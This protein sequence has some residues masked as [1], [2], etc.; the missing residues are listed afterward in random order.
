MNGWAVQVEEWV[1][2]RNNVGGG[3]MMVEGGEHGIAVVA[4]M[5]CNPGLG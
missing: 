3:T 2:G 1:S 4:S 5:R